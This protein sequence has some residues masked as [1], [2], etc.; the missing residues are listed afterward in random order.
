MPGTSRAV[1]RGIGRTALLA[2]GLLAIGSPGKSAIAAQTT[3]TCTP[4]DVADFPKSRIHVRCS[5][6]DGAIQWFALSV[7]DQQEASRVLSLAAAALVAK[8]HLTIWYDPADLSG[9]AIG[10]LTT[11]CR[12]IQGIRMY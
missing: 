2:L 10:C 11:D 1:P 6:A 9:A 3:F 7:A 8:K 12:L 4:V 5:P